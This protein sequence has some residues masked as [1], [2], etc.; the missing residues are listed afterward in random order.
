MGVTH[1]R[2]VATS[3]VLDGA[4]APTPVSMVPDAFGEE[5]AMPQPRY[6]PHTDRM[7][8]AE[9]DWVLTYD[10]VH[11]GFRYAPPGSKSTFDPATGGWHVAPPGSRPRFNVAESRWDLTPEGWEPTYNVATGRWELMPPRGER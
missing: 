9:A 1:G 3:S 7:E 2:R 11:G 5:I 8:L 10:L 6:N 4:N